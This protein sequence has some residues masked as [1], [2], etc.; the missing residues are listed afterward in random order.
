MRKLLM[1]GAILLIGSLGYGAQSADVIYDGENYK[2]DTTLT[3][4]TT[5]NVVDAVTNAVL[6]ITPLN[7][8]GAYGDRL[9][10]NFGD[11]APGDKT[12]LTGKFK[13]EVI[14]RKAEEPTEIMYGKLDTTNITVG[15]VENNGA[16]NNVEMKTTITRDVNNKGTT[17]SKLGTIS[18]TLGNGSGIK[19]S[20][21]TYEGEILSTFIA[22]TGAKSGNF[23]DTGVV[24]KVDVKNVA[25]E[26]PKSN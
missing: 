6:V 18:Y 4:K 21:R 9:M 8:T 19:N 24:V 14:Q 23:S 13:A 15:L 16:K 5:G 22:D 10:F 1:M 25:L 12:T 7:G 26:K 11:M 3:L 20:G 2:A 17:D